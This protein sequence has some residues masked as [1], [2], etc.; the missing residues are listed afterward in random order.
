[1]ET[2]S[3][4]KRIP[5]ATFIP[6]LLVIGGAIG[7]I[8]SFIIMFEKL[9]LLQNPT[10]TPSCDLNPIISCGSVMAS[11]QANAFGFPNPIIGL[12]SF[13]ILVA[14]GV[15]LLGGAKLRSWYWT[16]L[17]LGSLFGVV[18]VHW[19]FYQSVYVI[20]AL[21]PYC[22]VVWIVTI[23][24]FWYVTLYNIQLHFAR[25]PARLERL[26]VFVRKHHADIL[27][28]WLLIIAA[29]TLKHFW[30]YYGAFL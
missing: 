4:R 2:R 6:W 12:I 19:L 26:A 30:Y 29:L 14:T 10:Y 7:L 15:V 24:T 5:L 22:I 23:S 13:P 17:Q 28:F 21:C 25:I 1:M 18:F 27:V 20:E 16:G 8:C 3:K 11:A 9:E